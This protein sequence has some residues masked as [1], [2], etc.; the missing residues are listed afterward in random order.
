MDM[1]L[2]SYF[3]EIIALSESHE[4]TRAPVPERSSVDITFRTERVQD[5]IIF[6]HIKYS[7]LRASQ[8][9]TQYSR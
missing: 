5:R 1:V 8:S 2:V 7:Q 3:R 6:Y 4:Y 9:H